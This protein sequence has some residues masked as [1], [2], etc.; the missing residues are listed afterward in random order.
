MPRGR[1]LKKVTGAGSVSKP[2]SQNLQF[3]IVGIRGAEGL[4]DFALAM[5]RHLAV[6][7]EGRQYL[8]VAKILA[9]RLELFRRLAGALA[10][11]RER[12]PEAM[13]IEARQTS[14]LE[15]F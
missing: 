11:H 5:R 12:V 7:G 14:S 8:L 3:E 2:S 13:R 6:T 9:P 4:D 15:S 10:Q 1:G